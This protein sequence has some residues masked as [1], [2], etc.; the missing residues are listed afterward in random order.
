MEPLEFLRKGAHLLFRQGA[1]L[2][3]ILALFVF[4]ILEGTALKFEAIL[5]SFVHSLRQN[6]SG[7]FG[8]CGRIR[9]V[10]LSGRSAAW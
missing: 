4:S 2:P 6:Q 1:L 5:H 8:K 3:R 7:K 10:Q 9:D